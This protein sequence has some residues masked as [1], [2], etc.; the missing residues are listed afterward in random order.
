MKF[1]EANIGQEIE[2]RGRKD[3]GK[4]TKEEMRL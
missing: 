3:F 1:V 2:G 4:Q